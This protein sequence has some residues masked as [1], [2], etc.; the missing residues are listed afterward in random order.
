MIRLIAVIE[1]A[2]IARL[3]AAVRSEILECVR[4]EVANLERLARELKA[5]VGGA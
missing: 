2:L 5:F 4:V 3:A 1:Q